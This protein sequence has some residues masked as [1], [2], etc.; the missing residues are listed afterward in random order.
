MLHGFLAF[1]Y[2]GTYGNPARLLVHLTTSRI[3]GLHRHGETAPVSA[4]KFHEFTLLVRRTRILQNVPQTILESLQAVL[5]AILPGR[6][7]HVP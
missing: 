7:A 4:R 1:Q 6:M 2:T 5:G 3:L